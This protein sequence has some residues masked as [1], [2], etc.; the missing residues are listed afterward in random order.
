VFIITIYLYAFLNAFRFYYQRKRVLILILIKYFF[1]FTIFSFFFVIVYIFI[2]IILILI[3]GVGCGLEVISR[4]I[5]IRAKVFFI[6][7]RFP[8]RS[9]LFITVTIDYECLRLIF[10]R[11]LCLFSSKPILLFSRLITISLLYLFVIYYRA[12]SSKI[13]NKINKR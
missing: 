13:G 4:G 11:Y 2:I 5:R 6:S 10:R 7:L 8:F 9:F 12:N 3:S 1:F